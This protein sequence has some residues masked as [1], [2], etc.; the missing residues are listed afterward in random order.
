LKGKIVDAFGHPLAESNWVLRGAQRVTLEASPPPALSRRPIEGILETGVRSIDSFTP[1]GYGQRIGLFAPAGIGKSTLLGMLA[2]NAKVDVCVI[3]LV[4]ER[5]REVRELID[6]DLGPTAMTDCVLVVSTSDEPPL[7]RGLAALTATR[8]AEH[9]RDQG[10]EVLLLVDSLTRTARAWRESAL[11]T[12]EPAV[13][14]GYPASV[15]TAL[16][17][18]LERAGG[19]IRGS[20]TAIYTVLTQPDL[21]GDVLEDEIRSI[22]DGHLV[23][24][25]AL[26]ESGVRP[27]I[28][29]LKS[30]SRL[31]SRLASRAEREITMRCRRLMSRFERDRELI[32]LG[33]SPDPE[34]AA[35]MAIEPCIRDFMRQDPAERTERQQS[36]QIL[37]QILARAGP[38][39]D[40][41]SNLSG[42]SKTTAAD[43][44]CL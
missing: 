10:L 33:G 25:S 34:L 13:R 12:G 42:V 28:H 22:L 19:G 40:A 39:T 2:R 21:T 11:A 38:G 7:V 6:H 8:I 41:S 37:E 27:A 14:Q 23:M 18:L 9:F 26:A 20:I 36:I 44:S 5:G 32:L 35:A 31:E 29:P 17:R 30:L 16:P 1:L 15:F 4:G 3:A 43:Q 24:D